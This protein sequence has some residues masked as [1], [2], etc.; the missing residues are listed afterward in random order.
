MSFEDC[1]K[2]PLDVVQQ[3]YTEHAGG[4]GAAPDAAQGAIVK[5][6]EAVLANPAALQ[7]VIARGRWRAPQSAVWARAAGPETPARAGIASPAAFGAI[8]ARAARCAPCAVQPG[9]C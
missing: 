9:P 6:F 8:A 2:R 4:N 3:L 7:Q 5:H 1:V